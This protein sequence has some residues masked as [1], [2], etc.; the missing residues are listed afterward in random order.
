MMLAMEE[1]HKKLPAHYNIKTSIFAF[2][3][4]QAKLLQYG[5]EFTVLQATMQ[6]WYAYFYNNTFTV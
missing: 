5:S 2:S 6:K 1:M 4:M 3:S